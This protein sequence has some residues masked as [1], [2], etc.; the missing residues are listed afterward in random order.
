MIGAGERVDTVGGGVNLLKEWGVRSNKR[1]KAIFAGWNG[2][3]EMKQNHI[4]ARGYQWKEKGRVG[5][6]KGESQGAV[7]RQHIARGIQS[8]KSR[9]G[10]QSSVQ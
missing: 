6:E 4:L 8:G 3:Q 7:R 5:P 1:E 2:D 9:R 10:Q